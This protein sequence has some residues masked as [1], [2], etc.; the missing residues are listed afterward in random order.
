MSEKLDGTYWE[1]RYQED[2]LGWDIGYPSTPL[3]A[4]IDQLENKSIK[5]LVPGAGHGYEVAYLYQQGFTNVYAL[6]V[7]PTPL[8][9][10]KEMLPGFPESQLLQQDF[11]SLEEGD[12]DLILEQTFFCSL[13]PAR[14]EDYVTTTYRLLK[15][16]GTLAG[17]FFQFPLTEDGP[18]FGGNATMY[19]ELF[20]P[21]FQI[22]TL[23]T[24]YNSIPPRQG[25]ELFFIFTR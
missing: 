2:R 11:F 20:N 13:P 10:L 24:A 18:P 21:P 5:I 15:P 23:E 16:G 1:Q 4:Y 14:R 17:L 6:D 9:R 7:A 25:N 19:R 12:F 3:K 8:H 22:Q